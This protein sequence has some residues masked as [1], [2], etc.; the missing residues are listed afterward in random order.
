LTNTAFEKF[1]LLDQLAP[2]D[3]ERIADELEVE[4]LEA[5]EVLFHE[6][7]ASDGVVWLASGRVRVRREGIAGAAELEAGE[8][9]G[10]LSLV[11]EGPREATA[12]T[13]SRAEVWCLRRSGYGRLVASA[14]RTAG[15]LVEVI[16]RAY[17]ASVRA[18]LGRNEAP[19][20]DAS[21]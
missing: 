14:P 7:A 6:G 15:R 13:L 1:R 18:Q 8:A 2:E 11:V 12:E 16:L 9:M 21:A 4:A 17:A 5:G 19:R 10:T 3:R 20:G